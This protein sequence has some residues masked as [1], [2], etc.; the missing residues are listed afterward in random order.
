M[1]V[2]AFLVQITNYGKILLILKHTWVGIGKNVLAPMRPTNKSTK[3]VFFFEDPTWTL[4]HDYECPHLLSL[5][6]YTQ[7][8]KS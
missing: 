1:I 5:L 2:Q 3:K 8:K 4:Y 6:L 7:M